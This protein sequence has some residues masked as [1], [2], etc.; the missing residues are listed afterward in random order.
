MEYVQL[1]QYIL[2]HII[3]HYF[4]YYQHLFYCI[5]LYIVVL[6]KLLHCV[7]VIMITHGRNAP[8]SECFARIMLSMYAFVLTAFLFTS[9]TC[10]FIHVGCVTCIFKEKNNIDKAR[11]KLVKIIMQ[12]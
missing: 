9:S 6:Y 12:S 3:T 1:Q 4:I 11:L 5:R 2:Y 10:L 7:C 8:D